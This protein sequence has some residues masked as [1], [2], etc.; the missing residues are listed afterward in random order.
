MVSKFK[1][2][3]LAGV[4]ALPL[5]GGALAQ[6]AAPAAGVQSP[7]SAP[8]TAPATPSTVAPQA[9][10]ST[11]AETKADAKVDSKASAGDKAAVS[12]DKKAAHEEAAGSHRGE[13]KAGVVRKQHEEK[14]G[15]KTGLN[16]G[17]EAKKNQTAA[18]PSAGKGAKVD[19]GAGASTSTSVD[20]AKKL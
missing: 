2:F 12:T 10:V 19:G 17:L 15:E 1:A 20:P 5:A 13:H 9:G 14:A 18:A 8:V 11:K 16:G 3:L 7:T 4:F 6:T